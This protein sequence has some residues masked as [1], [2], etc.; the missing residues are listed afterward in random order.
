VGEIP[1]QVLV[2][3][4]AQRYNEPADYDRLAEALIRRLGRGQGRTA[5]AE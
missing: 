4:S 5:T 2:R 3:I 1:D